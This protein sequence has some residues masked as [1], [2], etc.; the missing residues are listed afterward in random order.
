MAL[1]VAR[2]PTVCQ[3]PVKAAKNQGIVSTSRLVQKCSNLA[4]DP[5]RM[6]CSWNEESIDGVIRSIRA[7]FNDCGGRTMPR[8]QPPSPVSGPLC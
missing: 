3:K 7:L 6:D 4:H 8:I 2:C 5:I 1:Q